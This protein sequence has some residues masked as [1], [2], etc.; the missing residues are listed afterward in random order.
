MN[1]GCG[2]SN[3]AIVTLMSQSLS[4]IVIVAPLQMLSPIVNRDDLL[5]VVR[6]MSIWCNLGIFVKEWLSSSVIVAV[7]Y[8]IV[9]S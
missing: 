3:R 7:K 8:L 6:G 9:M 1:R 4:V 5:A 2:F